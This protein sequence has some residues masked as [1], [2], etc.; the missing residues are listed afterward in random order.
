MGMLGVDWG[1]IDTHKLSLFIGF[2]ACN[3]Y[4]IV[5]WKDINWIDD[6]H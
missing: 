4:E 1:S 5:S 6:S 3:I 2:F